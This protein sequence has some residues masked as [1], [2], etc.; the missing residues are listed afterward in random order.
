MNISC[1]RHIRI[2]LRAMTIKTIKFPV[3]PRTSVKTYNPMVAFSHNKL[4]L[5]CASSEIFLRASDVLLF[6]MIFS[7][8]TRPWSKQMFCDYPNFT[9]FNFVDHPRNTLIKSCRHDSLQTAAV[10]LTEPANGITWLSPT[11][12]HACQSKVFQNSVAN[13]SDN[14]WGKLPVVFNLKTPHIRNTKQKRL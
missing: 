6:M 3:K 1:G 2:F 8:I 5:C 4:F 12:T 11:V 9:F 7:R 13:T 14:E 10:K